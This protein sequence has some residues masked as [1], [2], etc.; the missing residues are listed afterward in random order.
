MGDLAGLQGRLTKVLIENLEI[1]K[2]FEMQL[3]AGHVRLRFVDSVYADLS[4]ELEDSTRICST[5]GCP[6]CSAMGCILAA[7]TMR[8]VAFEGESL[9]ENGRIMEAHYRILQE[10]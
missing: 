5:M 1:V 8:P 9:S 6:I 2:D 7:S 3:E 10:D 4:K